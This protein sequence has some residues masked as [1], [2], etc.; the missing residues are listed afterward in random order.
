MLP[1]VWKGPFSDPHLSG[2][3]Y[4]E[5]RVDSLASQECLLQGPSKKRWPEGV[6]TIA[7][8][9]LDILSM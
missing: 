1:D 7:G 4:L 8:G 3:T 6:E 2:I 5:S 9:P